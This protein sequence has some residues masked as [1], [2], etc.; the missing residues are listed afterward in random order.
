MKISQRAATLDDLEWLE[1]FYESIMRP[2]YVELNWEW[3]KTKFRESFDPNVTKIIQADGIDIG[4]LKVEERDDC[5][6]LGDIQLDRAYRRKGIGTQ[7]IK[8]AIES[9]I[10]AS[11]PIRLRVL[12]G[13]PAKDLYLRLGFGEIQAL[14]NCY[15]MERN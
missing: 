11:K 15:L 14:D 6:Y 12:K 1:P 8:T 5:I 9:A 2:Y 7:L 4:M 3:D 13:N 10:L